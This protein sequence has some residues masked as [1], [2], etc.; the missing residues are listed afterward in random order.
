MSPYDS[1]LKS[2]CIIVFYSS[3]VMNS[4]LFLNLL[5]YHERN[6]FKRQITY[7][8]FSL[9]QHWCCSL[10]LRFFFFWKLFTIRAISNFKNSMIFDFR[11]SIQILGAPFGWIDY[12]GSIL[13]TVPFHQL[14]NFS[15][16]DS[17]LLK[18]KALWFYAYNY[19]N[20][21]FKKYNLTCQNTLWIC[22]DH[23]K[24]MILYFHWTE[25]LNPWKFYFFL[26]FILCWNNSSIL[27]H[28]YWTM[29]DLFVC[30][31]LVQ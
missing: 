17:H 31:F 28:H 24:K 7:W 27:C 8:T 9:F 30:L 15:K 5:Y 26:A 21:V 13:L 4:W 29:V 11:S 12:F 10:L 25:H 16:A 2:M 6:H 19:Y 23:K 18:I 22:F 1:V 3:L 14:Q 20:E